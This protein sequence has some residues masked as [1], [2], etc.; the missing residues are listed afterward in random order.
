VGAGGGWEYFGRGRFT[1]K[2][3]RQ[4]KLR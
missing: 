2:S 4:T 1:T 3:E